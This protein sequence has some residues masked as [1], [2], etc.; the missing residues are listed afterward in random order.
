MLFSCFQHLAR[1]WQLKFPMYKTMEWFGGESSHHKQI[2][3]DEQPNKAPTFYRGGGKYY[4]ETLF[5]LCDT[6]GGSKGGG[7]Q[8]CVPLPSPN[9]FIFMQFSAK[10]CNNRLAHPL[11]ELAPPQENPGSATEH[12]SSSAPA[13]WYYRRAEKDT[14]W[15]GKSWKYCRVTRVG[16]ATQACKLRNNRKK[17]CAHRTL[18]RSYLW[19]GLFSFECL[20]SIIFTTLRYKLQG[21]TSHC[22]H[23]TEVV[24]I[25]GL[26]SNIE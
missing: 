14:V 18:I 22:L 23:G 5:S 6:I 11:W 15:T 4:M 3:V 9:S 1:R 20:A 2:K 8:G 26:W 10:N 12:S 16:P 21:H 17:C 7:C 19:I 25:I 13:H 24:P